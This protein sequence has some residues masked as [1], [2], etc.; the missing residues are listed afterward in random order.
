MTGQKKTRGE[1]R[2]REMEKA[3]FLGSGGNV[4]GLLSE[5]KP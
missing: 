2:W 3:A 4:S 1:V 5:I